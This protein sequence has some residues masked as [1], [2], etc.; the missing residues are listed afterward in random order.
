MITKTATAKPIKSMNPRS[1][2]TVQM[3]SEPEWKM[4]PDPNGRATALTRMFVWYNYFYSKKEAKECI[5]DWLARNDRMGEAKH[6]ARVP[7]SAV[8]MTIG[9]VC[10]ASVKGLELTE[11][12]LQQVNAHIAEQLSVQHSVKTIVE[13]PEPVVQKPNIQD[14]LRER[15]SE[16]AGELEGMFDELVDS[17]A[18]MGANFKPLSLMR[19]MNVAPQLISTIRDIW[20]RRID[21]F[22]E[23]LAGQDSQLVEGYAHLGK[24]QVRNLIKF[25]EQVVADCDSYVQIKKADRK[26]RAKKAASPEKISAKFKFQTEFV[27]L[28]LKSEAPAQ[29]VGASEAWL[30]DTKKR[31]LIHVVADQHIGTFT[32][33]GSSLVGFDP[34]NSLQKT[35]RKPAEQ[36][37]GIVGA[38]KPAARKHFKEIKSTEVKFNGRSNENLVI[39]KVW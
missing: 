7:E 21:E 36:L 34:G 25:A 30:Y 2:D 27:E 18:K 32:V 35:L 4:Q 10:R 23:V 31:K 13:S 14:R 5:M 38:G 6:F 20:N 39:L 3:G 19:S 12:E 9:W 28:K 33:K 1:S 26:P 8:T 37:K 22:N 24:V 15:M 11:R 17:G 16:A 29:L